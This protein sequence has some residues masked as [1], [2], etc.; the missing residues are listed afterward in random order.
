MLGLQDLWY[1]ELSAVIESSY[2][3][4][5]IVNQDGMIERVN[6]SY[7]RITGLSREDVVGQ[8]ARDLVALGVMSNSV[9][10]RIILEKKPV[11]L[12][13]RYST[14]RSAVV[15][16]SPVFGPDGS[17]R[18]VII[19]IRDVT[20][21]YSLNEELER[22]RDLNERY[23]TEAE[24]L[25]NAQTLQDGVVCQSRRMRELLALVQ[26]VARVDS[27]VLLTGES[28]VGKGVI[29]RY[30][31]KISPRSGGPFV[32]V[33]CAA[34][35]EQLLESELFGYEAGAF[36][37][38]RRSG[39]VGV[40]ELADGGTLLLDEVAEMSP[41]LQAK[42]L[43][44]LQD[45]EFRRVGGTKPVAVDVRL[46][47]ATNRDLEGM[48]TA[49][50]FR[51]DLFYRLNV[52]PLRVPALRDRPEDVVAL[53]MNFVE[54]F[55]SRYR[56]KRR[57]TNEAITCLLAYHW[58]GNV[59]ELENAIERAVVT[60]PSEEIGPSALPEAVRSSQR[61]QPQSLQEALVEVERRYYLEACS[62]CSS[63]YEVARMLGVS[64]ATA[65]RKTRQYLGH[66]FISENY[67][68]HAN[69]PSRRRAS[70]IA[71]L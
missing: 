21:L 68:S 10:D 40:F 13:T 54:R 43:Q 23:R 46:I 36:T 63:T 55:S 3:G 70:A 53:T 19:N 2:D 1:D 56:L 45:R 34:I 60:C 17:V 11:M 9:T 51:E 59:R 42:L 31:H 18:K 52:V 26:T 49:G 14:G 12:T 66:S 20:E 22:T 6:A 5:V 67:N 48:V 35:P 58:P 33:N 50:T 39:K 71:S 62:Q 4:I 27:T 25:R 15:V 41:P 37:G 28:G 8:R 32:H 47:A 38:A 30:I 57:L 64:Q 61:P 69:R 24:R 16:G 44:V 29:A 7:L 65:Y